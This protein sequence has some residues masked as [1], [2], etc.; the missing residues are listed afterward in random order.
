MEIWSINDEQ[1]MVLRLSDLAVSAMEEDNLNFST[2][3]PSDFFCRI[4]ENY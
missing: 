3:S 1:R 2:K 4:F